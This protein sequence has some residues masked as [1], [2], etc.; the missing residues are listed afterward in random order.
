MTDTRFK[1]SSSSKI[2]I[3]KKAADGDPEAQYQFARLLQR[4]NATD[5]N[6]NT[7]MYW[8]EK[9]ADQEFT[10][11]QF[12]KGIYY[13][14]GTEVEKDEKKGFANIKIAA[15]KGLPIALNNMGICFEEGIGVEKNQKTAAAFYQK[16]AE[17]DFPHAQ[18]SL[19]IC[20]EEGEGIEKDIDAAEYW[21]RKAV[22]HKY[23]PALY[24]LAW[25]LKKRDGKSVDTK[26]IA[27]LFQQGAELGDADAQLEFAFCLCN[28]QGVE[29]NSEAGIYWLKQA[30]NQGVLKAEEYLGVYYEFGRGVTENIRTAIKWYSKA[31]NS[32]SRS[33]QSHLGML[34]LTTEGV[35]NPRKAKKWLRKAAE[36]GDKFALQFI[37][38]NITANPK[39]L[40]ISPDSKNVHIPP[41]NEIPT[42]R[43]VGP[44][45]GCAAFATAI[46]C[47]KLLNFKLFGY[48]NPK[49]LADE[50]SNNNVVLTQ[51]NKLYAQGKIMYETP[52]AIY[53]V[54]TFSKLA[55]S[56]GVPGCKAI[57][58]SHYSKE[59]Y[60]SVIQ[61]ELDK[62]NF[63]I[64]ACET[65]DSLPSQSNGL[66]T[67]WVLAYG[68]QIHPD[69]GMQIKI[70]H[71]GLHCN[72]SA[73]EL[74]E[75]NNKLPRKN[76]YASYFYN[77][78][79]KSLVLKS[80]SQ[81]NPLKQYKSQAYLN[82]FRFAL[83]S[84]PTH[85]A[86]TT[87]LGYYRDKLCKFF[88][89]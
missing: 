7:A 49:Q 47:S 71:F 33:S 55:E 50:K 28:G 38:R 56:F 65:K 58:K 9:S 72:W 73:Q 36:Q 74:Y 41:F 69:H 21:Y 30:A 1:S 59:E 88:G 34:L 83:F 11:A 64:V 18:Y 77:E 63:L 61:S 19:A 79:D 32:G 29:K 51:I 85:K 67:H 60:L 84:V 80:N 23:G 17:K 27:T 40:A 57:I 13:I 78:R 3:N 45:C 48:H 43:Q 8:L 12:L 15:E 14:D 31:A 44:T 2:A 81:I 20:Y 46:N 89:S 53:N 4:S 87:T 10:P 26:M 86:T 42:V 35:K 62:K 5:T 25:L 82:F 52:G 66:N 75:S 39:S 22:D 6:G 37:K 76:R 54:Y 68:Y 16:A 24:S 70:T